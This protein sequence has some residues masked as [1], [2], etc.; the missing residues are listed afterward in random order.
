MV[1]KVFFIF[2]L[3]LMGGCSTQPT[4]EK[5][6]LGIT[7]LQQDNATQFLQTMLPIISPESS[8]VEVYRIGP[9]DELVVNIWGREDLG[10]QIMEGDDSG[11]R[12]S[13]VQEDGTLLLPFL[14]PL[15]VRGLT[16]KD[17]TRLISHSYRKII[18]DPQVEVRVVGYRSKPIYLE[19][20]VSRPGVVYLSP[21]IRTLAAV[22][23]SVGG[24]ERDAAGNYGVLVRE[25]KRYRL[26]YR[27]SDGSFGPAANIQMQAGDWV[28]FPRVSEQVVYVF[29]EVG[30]QRKLAIPTHGLTLMEALADVNGFDRVS[31]N[32]DKIYL[33]RPTPRESRIYRMTMTELMETPDTQLQ[34]GDR[35]LVP[36]TGLAKWDRTWRQ[37][38]PFFSAS[39]SSNN[40]YRTVNDTAN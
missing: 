27:E 18:Q 33:L 30:L 20:G 10:S 28:Q 26:I 14:E 13:L 19:R 1:R 15:K 32:L 34:P 9:R 21:D 38:L 35:L 29:G 22:I 2:G 6:L 4:W 17:L 37:L 5:N 23:A 12:V 25:G 11:R 16:V 8:P 36:P 24:L 31:A 39:D 40:I 3:L 7:E